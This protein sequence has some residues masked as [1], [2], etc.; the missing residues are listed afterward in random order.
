M[1]NLSISRNHQPVDEYALRQDIVTIG[2]GSENDIQLSDTTV[3]HHHA[4]F[5][6]SHNSLIV[7]DL[8]STN[9]TYVNGLRIKRQQ[10]KN[11]DEVTIGQHKLSF[12]NINSPDDELEHEP[13]LQMSRHSIE[14]MLVNGQINPTPPPATNDTKAINWVAQDQNGVWWGF[15]QQPV[16]K[17]SGWSNFQ[18][19]MKLKLKQETPNPQWRDTLHKV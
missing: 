7:E 5:L 12:D 3:S 6:I 13:T 10:L 19:T 8:N 17:S 9:G 14:Q 2:R 18:D 16:A 1:Y 15:E 4:Q 11:G